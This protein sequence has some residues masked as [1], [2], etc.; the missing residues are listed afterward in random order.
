MQTEYDFND[1]S[2]FSRQ[3]S[4]VQSR[5]DVDLRQKISIGDN[6][7]WVNPIIAAPMRDTAGPSMCN[8]MESKNN[9]AGV[10]HRFHKTHD[11][12]VEDIRELIGEN[13]ENRLVSFSVSMTDGQE[14]RDKLNYLIANFN[15]VSFIICIDTANG[16]SKG[17]ENMVNLIQTHA[18]DDLNYELM[19]GN[20]VTKEAAEY[21]Y[22]LG[23]NYLRVGIGG[24]AVC[25]TPTETGIFRPYANA[26]KEIRE[27]LDWLGA[28]DAK[29][30][31]DGGMRGTDRI[32]KAL[33]LGA[34][35]VMLGYLLAGWERSNSPLVKKGFLKKKKYKYYRGSASKEMALAAGKSMDKLIVEGVE[36]LI[37]YKGDDY[38]FEKFYNQLEGAMKSCMSY[39]DSKKL[40]EFKSKCEIV[41]VTGAS[42][43]IRSQVDA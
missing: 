36:R 3:I 16:A 17:V 27:H 2:L 11:E 15:K 38:D 32:M 18:E 40:D 33:A 41:L 1:V 8:Y 22:N 20:I 35:F 26:I 7:Y 24:G 9:I 39:C 4:S 19:C 12:W 23:V 37:P 25:S 30:V 34:D 14:V 21:L 42:N 28:T 29:I 5:H 31:A 13:N 10:L 43:Q 6:S